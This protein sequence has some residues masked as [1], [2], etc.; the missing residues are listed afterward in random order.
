VH[1]PTCICEELV[2]KQNKKGWR[3]Q[4]P[5]ILNLCIRDSDH[6]YDGGNGNHR[7][8]KLLRIDLDKDTSVRG[9]RHLESGENHS[10]VHAVGSLCLTTIIECQL[11][12]QILH[13]LRIQGHPVG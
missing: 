13:M 5:L 3:K 11:Y 10:N 8:N 4:L 12:R 2:R 6:Q 7:S 9:K 1:R